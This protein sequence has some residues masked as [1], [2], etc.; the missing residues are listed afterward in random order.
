MFVVVLGLRCKQLPHIKSKYIENHIL[1]TH[2]FQFSTT[3]VYFIKRYTPFLLIFK[4]GL[5]TNT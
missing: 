1:N 3:H 5:S 4:D 2:R